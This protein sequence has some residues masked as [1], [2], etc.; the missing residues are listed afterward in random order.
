MM[1]DK[2]YIGANTIDGIVAVLPHR[3]SEAILAVNKKSI[4]SELDEQE[5]WRRT[6]TAA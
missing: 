3:K 4:T 6:I 2:G 5:W 1:G